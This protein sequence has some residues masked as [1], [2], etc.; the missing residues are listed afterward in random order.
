MSADT[1]QPWL[2]G[3]F[4]RRPSFDFSLPPDPDGF[5]ARAGSGLVGS[6]TP[7]GR[8]PSGPGMIDLGLGG[9]NPGQGSMGG[10]A[11]VGPNFGPSPAGSTLSAGP[12][13]VVPQQST[14]PGLMGAMGIG[15]GPMGAQAGS[16]MGMG[17]MDKWG[18]TAPQIKSD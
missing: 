17:T 18:T 4:S 10:P 16:G 13:Q 7:Q 15:G 5:D 11:S 6:S 8:G 9:M 3:L 1:T 14:A 2:S 12:Q